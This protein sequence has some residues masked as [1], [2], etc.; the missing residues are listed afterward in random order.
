MK[1]VNLAILASFSSSMAFA[2]GFARQ[3][4]ELPTKRAWIG[5]RPERWFDR[6]AFRLPCRCTPR[7]HGDAVG[8]ESLDDARSLG[9]VFGDSR[10]LADNFRADVAPVQR[11]NRALRRR[12]DA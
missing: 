2:A 11:E 7:R 10:R 1:K 12:L 4:H 6:A 8:G 9:A 3:P 5:V